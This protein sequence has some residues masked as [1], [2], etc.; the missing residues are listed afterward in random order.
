VRIK[1]L[2]LAASMMIFSILILFG[3]PDAQAGSDS[4]CIVTPSFQEVYLAP[5]GSTNITTQISCT[6]FVHDFTNI[7]IDDTSSCALLISNDF[8][9][10]SRATSDGFIQDTY[11]E[12]HT[13]SYT[14]DNSYDQAFCH[15]KYTT[16]G[17]AE[18]SVFQQIRVIV[19]DE[20]A[21][22]SCFT[23]PDYDIVRR[24]ALGESRSVSLSVTCTSPFGITDIVPDTSDCEPDVDISFGPSFTSTTEF[25]RTETYTDTVTI[26]NVAKEYPP[27]IHDCE[28][29]WNATGE[30]TPSTQQT[31]TVIT[32]QSYA[33][34]EIFGPSFLEKDETYY[35]TISLSNNGPIPLDCGPVFL[36]PP[37][38]EVIPPTVLLIDETVVSSFE[39]TPTENSVQ[40]DASVSCT[41]FPS[42]N[43]PYDD[44]AVYIN[45]VGGVFGGVSLIPTPRENPIYEGGYFEVDYAVTNTGSVEIH[46]E[47]LVDNT[48][49]FNKPIVP[50]DIAPGET[51]LVWNAGLMWGDTTVKASVECVDEAGNTVVDNS[52][53]DALTMDPPI[54]ISITC[55]PIRSIEPSILTWTAIID[56][57]QLNGDITLRKYEASAQFVYG[58]SVGMSDHPFTEGYGNYELGA[59]DLVD[60]FT[61]NVPLDEAAYTG[62]M[63]VWGFDSFGHFRVNHLTQDAN[64][65]CNVVSYTPD[66]IPD[67]IREIE[68]S[69][70][71]NN[72]E[73]S[74]LAPLKKVFKILN[75]GNPNNDLAACDKLTHFLNNLAAKEDKIDDP[76]L[77]DEWE[78]YVQSIKEALG[79]PVD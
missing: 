75:D 77:V 24:I 63:F 28:L 62:N 1:N 27:R 34:L 56:N 32:D 26:T 59:S 53:I 15:I 49:G 47:E 13:I 55:N 37:V 23:I 20:G 66:L 78:V 22:P 8:G 11:T 71:P 74:L 29:E 46:C 73:N 54:T 43:V 30:L 72:V 69:N 70:L 38:E 44:H 42:G 12:T 21:V 2:L 4:G 41:E 16:E 5:G 64:N 45:N 50:Q 67:L 35:L 19:V 57:H 18:F 51:V 6:S 68:T 36:D 9:V 10:R 60:V 52:T 65:L 14:G 76:D 7:V 48:F 31:V 25:S 58:G 61:S 3:I 39:F 40:F 17:D 33:D 79:C